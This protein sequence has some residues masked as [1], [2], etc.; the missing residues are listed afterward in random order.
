MVFFTGQRALAVDPRDGRLL[1]SYNRASNSTANIATPVIRGNRVFFSS[2][3]GT[4]AGLVQVKAAGNDR[5]RRGGVLHARDAQPPRVVRAGGRHIY[6]FSDSILTALNFDTG[7]LAWRDRSVGKG[8][9]IY[10]DQRLYL[11]SENG[12][13]GLAEADAGCVSR[14]R[15]ILDPDGTAHPPGA[16]RSSP[17]AG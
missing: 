5:V 6:G 3:Y 2:D 1:W 4:G 12:V 7:E 11:Y 16:I 13:V 9:L 14:A 8:S 17:T 10:A 15:T